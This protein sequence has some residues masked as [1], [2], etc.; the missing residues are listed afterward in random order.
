MTNRILI[1]GI[2]NLLM[3]D[4]GFGPSVINS[5]ENEA[6][7]ENIELRDIGIAGITMIAELEDFD[8][9]IFIDAMNIEGEYGSLKIIKVNVENITSEEALELSK[10]SIHE[11]DLEAL[12][13]LAKTIGTLPEEVYI[14]G[15]KPE[16]L[17]IEHGL[18]PKVRKAVPEAVK[19]IKELI[20]KIY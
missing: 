1:A 20:N 4:D 11:I 7:P 12:L 8:S 10:F 15:C 18:S 13:K 3:G 17:D 9:V 14:V 5:L 2:G 16:K 6:I 19:Q